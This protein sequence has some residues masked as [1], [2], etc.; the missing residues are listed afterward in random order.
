MPL[1]HILF[2]ERVFS[3]VFQDKL[4]TDIFANSVIVTFSIMY[5]F[6]HSIVDILVHICNFEVEK[7]FSF[8]ESCKC[9]FKIVKK[10]LK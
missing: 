8:H 10:L 5:S 4:S 2:V 6:Q 1:L 3:S 9:L 7:L